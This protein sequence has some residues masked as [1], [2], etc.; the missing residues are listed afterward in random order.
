[1]AANIFGRYI[2]LI[3]LIRCR[4]YITFKEISRKWEDSELG[5]GKPLPWKTFM[6][7][8]EAIQSIFDVLISCDAKR[9]YGYYIEDAKQL[10]G[11]TF[12]RWLIDSYAT[13]NQLQ[14]DRK[15]EKRVSFEKIPSGNRFLQLLFQAIHQNLVV[16]ITHHGFGKSH[17]S[18]FPVAPYHLKVYNRRWYLVGLSVYS[19]E[20]RTYALDRIQ[21]AIL[22]KETFELPKSF[23]IDKYFEGCVGVITDKN[24]CIEHVVIKAYGWARKYLTT[25]PLHDSQHEIASDEES[26]TFELTVR[27]TYEFFQLILQQTDQIE[28]IRPL[29]VQEEMCRIATNILAYYKKNNQSPQ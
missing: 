7:H 13:L 15:L 28:I 23:D 24:T 8:K 14:A 18:T 17:A 21:K 19:N 4:P 20:I 6:N 9:G 11:D 16:E 25:L 27:P 10:E 3:N 1:M 12:R 2:W 26:T 5:N 29:W 22:T